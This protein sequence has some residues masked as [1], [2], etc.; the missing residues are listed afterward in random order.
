MGR[1]EL[2]THER[3]EVLITGGPCTVTSARSNEGWPGRHGMHEITLLLSEDLMYHLS[4]HS[5]QLFLKGL[6]PRPNL[7]LHVRVDQSR[8]AVLDSYPDHG[9][10]TQKYL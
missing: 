4:T 8:T 10:Q 6:E 2:Q 9:Y 5:A 7:F 1:L 3:V